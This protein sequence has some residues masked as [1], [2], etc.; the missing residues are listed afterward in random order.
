MIE[1]LRSPLEFDG[2]NDMAFLLGEKTNCPI[3]RP[4]G[5]HP[6][7]SSQLPL[8]FACRGHGRIAKHIAEN[9]IEETAMETHFLGF[10]K[11][12]LGQVLQPNAQGLLMAIEKVGINPLDTIT[13]EPGVK[14]RNVAV[15]SNHNCC[16]YPH[17]V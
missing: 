12:P 14:E 2:C 15:T 6:F 3:S 13:Y 7:F 11:R 17:M 10:I 1:E 8:P 16:F 4:A 5:K 9:P